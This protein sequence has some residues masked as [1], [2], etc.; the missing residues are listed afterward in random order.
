MRTGRVQVGSV[1]SRQIGIVAGPCHVSMIIVVGGCDC[2]GVVCGS[3]LVGGD[4]LGEFFELGAPAQ[5]DGQFGADG[6][7]FRDVEGGGLFEGGGSIFEEDLRQF[8][9]QCDGLTH[10]F[11]LHVT[12]LLHDQLAEEES[13]GEAGV[14]AH[15]VNVPLWFVVLHL[16]IIKEYP[17]TNNNTRDQG[18]AR[19]TIRHIITTHHSSSTYSPTH[20]L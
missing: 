1:L 9:D 3:F 8:G 10:A 6:L 17:T 11:H 13:L 18:M 19:L 5:A 12:V 7:A 16:N 2:K 15:A 4:V 20:N 14:A